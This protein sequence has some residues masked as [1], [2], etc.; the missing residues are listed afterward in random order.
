MANVVKLHLLRGQIVRVTELFT[1][2]K[3]EQ[4]VPYGEVWWAVCV[5]DDSGLEWINAGPELDI[6]E[7]H[8]EFEVFEADEAPDEYYVEVAKYALLGKPNDEEDEEDA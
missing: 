1:D 3:S 7:N 2:N 4:V 5:D 8:D 6:W